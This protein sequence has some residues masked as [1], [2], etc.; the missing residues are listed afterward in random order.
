MTIRFSHLKQM[1]IIDDAIVKTTD[2]LFVLVGRL[3]G[4][5]IRV[6]IFEYFRDVI[7]SM[8]ILKVRIG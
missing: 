5:D 8:S 6:H 2:E 7:S 3:M 1:A 4:F